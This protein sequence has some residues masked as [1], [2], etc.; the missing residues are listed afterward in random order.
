MSAQVTP[1]TLMMKWA[2]AARRAEVLA[3]KATMLA[4][5]VVPMFSPSTS[6]MPWS[7]WS[8]PVEQRVIVMAMMAADDCTQRVSTVPMSRKKRVF[9]ILD[10]LNC[11]KNRLM[12]AP[13]MGSS[14]SEKL[15]SFRVIKP[16]NRNATPKR[17]S[18]MMRLL[19][20]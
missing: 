15:V 7:I 3:V 17:K 2:K 8:T 1:M 13:V 5:M 14:T 4:V 12:V 10:S 16:R 6:M 18:P 9:P 19:F 20:I 11:W